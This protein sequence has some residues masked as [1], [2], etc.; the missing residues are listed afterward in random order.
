MLSYETISDA[1]LDSAEEVGLNVWQSDEQL[2]PHTLLRTF[3]LTCL[4]PGQTAPRPSSL[5]ATMSFRWDAA[6]TAIS[7]IGTEA[8][9]KLYHGEN[10]G[11]AHDLT[12]CAYEAALALEVAYALPLTLQLKDE[13]ELLA[14]VTRSIQELHRGMVDHKNL[15]KVDADVQVVN[16]EMQVRRLKAR[17]VWTIGDALHDLDGLE[18]V[19]EEACTEARD[20]LHALTQRF[21][22]NAKLVEGSDESPLPMV[23]ESDEDRI[24]LRPPTA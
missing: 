6:M 2:D 1:L 17:Q 10:V 21:T 19:L 23:L 12:G 18:D 20:L 5:Q 4:P 3:T 11:C 13:P 14:R 24:Y 16:G 9:C 15:V 7:T 22:G 8:I